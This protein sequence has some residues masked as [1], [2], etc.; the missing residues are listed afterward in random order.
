MVKIMNE[1]KVDM[2]FMSTVGEENNK[3]NP[4]WSDYISEP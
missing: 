2:I 3:Y 4:S 1:I